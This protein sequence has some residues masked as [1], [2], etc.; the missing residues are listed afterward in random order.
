MGMPP[1]TH[2]GGIDMLG[3][4]LQGMN[5]MPRDEGLGDSPPTT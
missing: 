1:P 4:R 5:L 2:R 3:T